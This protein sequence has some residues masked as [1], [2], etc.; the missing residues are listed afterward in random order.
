MIEKYSKPSAILG[1]V[2]AFTIFLSYE[3]APDQ[4]EGI[5]VFILQLLFFTSIITG[6]L[7]LIFSYVARRHKEDGFLKNIAPFILL[8]IA[9]VFAISFLGIIVSFI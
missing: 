5:T 4:P 6:V 2:C 7:S 8:L 9:T 3:F 1:I